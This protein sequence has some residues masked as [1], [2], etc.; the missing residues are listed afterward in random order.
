MD[1][2]L[3]SAL[4][5]RDGLI[6][7]LP[8]LQRRAEKSSV[9]DAPSLVDLDQ[10]EY[11]RLKNH[12]QEVVRQQMNLDEVARSRD[13]VV[14]NRF[15]SIV[16]RAMRD[17]DIKVASLA[18]PSLVQKLFDDILGYGILEKFFFDPEVTEIIV[19]G[20]RVQIMKRG[21]RIFV[22]EQFESVEQARQVVERMLAP[23]GRRLDLA[24]PRVS[25]RL[26]D[27]SRMMAHIAPCAVDGVLATIRRFRQ[28]ITP[29]MLLKNRSISR[30]V[31]DFMRACILARRNM[32][33]AGGTGSVKTTFVNVLASFIPHD[34]SVVTVED[35]A[36]LQLQHPDVRRLEGRPPNIE[37]KGEITL[38]DLVK[39]AL[40]MFPDRIIVGECRGE[41]AFDMLQAMNTGHP[42]SLTTIHANS[43]RHA[44][45]RLVNM[46]QT[47]GMEL[48]RDAVLDQIADAVD[49]IVF[50]LREKSGRRRLDHVVEVVGPERGA[51][52]I[53]RDVKLNVLWRYNP[54]TDSF[55]WVAKEFKRAEILAEKGG[56]R[57]PYL[58]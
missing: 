30:E 12:V 20:T 27:G 53:I 57:C 18:V 3:V 48:P 33:I 58:S 39:D 4:A 41:E 51:D 56:W 16:L 32:V 35:T 28:D 55:E 22:Q 11:T 47:A 42:G 37:G 34:E 40:R 45:N 14:R 54:K 49:I 17:L 46:V 15:K 29:E 9:A 50:I 19:N 38:R 31:L 36:E 44:I 43:A 25:A 6:S 5:A 2:T 8:F 1:L 7:P 52:G 10:E 13:P 21:R 26:F 24:N 23:T